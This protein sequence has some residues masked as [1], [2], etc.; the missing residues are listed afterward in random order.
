MP[1]PVGTSETVLGLPL[2]DYT[3]TVENWSWR[4]EETGR[5]YELS[6]DGNKDLQFEFAAP[7]ADDTGYYY[8]TDNSHN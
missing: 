8:I 4:Y 6:F 7:A 3:I 1:E 2:G 5:V